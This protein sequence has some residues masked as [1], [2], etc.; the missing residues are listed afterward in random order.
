MNEATFIDYDG[1]HFF[2]CWTLVGFVHRKTSLCW[3]VARFFYGTEVCTGQL[4]ITASARGGLP[5][6]RSQ[7]A[8]GALVVSW[9]RL[10]PQ[11]CLRF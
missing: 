3:G 8:K 11:L 10:T 5:P 2:R 4:S 1:G 9:L 6:A 7:Q